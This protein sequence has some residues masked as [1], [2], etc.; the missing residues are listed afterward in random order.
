VVLFA[1]IERRFKFPQLTTAVYFAGL[2]VLLSGGLATAQ[3]YFQTWATDPILY[4][5]SDGDLA[6]AADYLDRQDLSGLSVYVAAPHYKHPTVAFLSDAYAQVKWLP[7][8]QALVL[9]ASGPALFLFPHNSPAPSWALP[10]LA[11]AQLTEAHTLGYLPGSFRA[12]TLAQNPPTTPPQPLD[13]N[14][15]Q[16]ITLLGYDFVPAAAA[17][18]LPLTLFW[19]VTG[20]PTADF[21]P[22]VQLEDA[23]GH[24]WSQVEAFA[25][26]AEQWAP[27]ETIIQQVQVPVPAG[28]PPGT[29]RL[30]VGLF[31]ADS[32]ARAP[33]IDEDGSYAGDSIFIEDV[34]ITVGPLPPALPRPPFIVKEEALPGLFLEGFERGPAFTT[35]GAPWGFALWWVA[36]EPLPHL[37][38]HLDL[39]DEAGASRTL[40]RTQ[41]VH[42]TLPFASWPAP[43]F[44]I[45]RQTLTLPSDFPPGSYLLSMRLV[46][47]AGETRYETELGSLQV[48]ATERVYDAP[49]LRIPTQAIFGGE[50]ALRSYQMTAVDANQTQLT[51]QW[52]AVQTPTGDYTVFVH[53]L[54]QDGTCCV[55]QQDSMPLAG[56]YPTSRWLAGEFVND[57]IPISLPPDLSPG[58]YPLEIGLYIADTGQRLQVERAGRPAGDALLLEPLQIP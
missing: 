26:P 11:E 13:A 31:D 57:I 7:E 29:Y 35:T 33:R 6:A 46:D 53:V 48:E 27:G 41:P 16:S 50:I 23:W 55:W 38:I 36:T 9:P 34:P 12:Y 18:R 44:L 56:A 37:T 1:D 49:P 5:E 20:S 58:T 15:D 24:R 52:Q 40:L 32:G 45:D 3:T 30:R 19:R 28:A 8:S 25:Y 10:Y 39:L 14:F 47:K 43:G 2:L 4:F 42:D 17:S 22:F 21:L 54:N 51:L